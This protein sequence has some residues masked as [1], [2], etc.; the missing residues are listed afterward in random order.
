MRSPSIKFARK[1]AM[2]KRHAPKK[3]AKTAS[4]K[5]TTKKNR[6]MPAQMAGHVKHSGPVKGRGDDRVSVEPSRALAQITQET[7]SPAV[8]PFE[9]SALR[10]V[11]A[12]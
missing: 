12:S 4:A 5:K 6:A 10:S 2:T 9:P 1:L 11:A 3:S 7:V 8:Q